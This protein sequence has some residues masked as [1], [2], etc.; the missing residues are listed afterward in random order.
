MSRAGILSILCTVMSVTLFFVFRGPTA[1]LWTIAVT[2]AALS[3]VGMLFAFLSKRLP[4]I[5]AGGLLNGA[6]LIVAFLLFLAHGV[7]ER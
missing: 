5:I 4:W 2:L 1:D 6:I 7:G 3:V